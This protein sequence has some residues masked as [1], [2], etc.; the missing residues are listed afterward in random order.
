MLPPQHLAAP[1]PRTLMAQ[2]ITLKQASPALLRSWEGGGS[3][4][5]EENQVFSVGM[6]PNSLKNFGNFLFNSHHYLLISAPSPVWCQEEHQTGAWGNLGMLVSALSTG[7]NQGNCLSLK[8]NISIFPNGIILVRIQVTKLW[9]RFIKEIKRR[10][11]VNLPWNL[12]YLN[13]W[14]PLPVGK[15]R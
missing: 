14:S 3:F 11:T 6:L 1:P 15:F 4:L 8:I 5:V 13:I 2:S 12:E 9:Y 10:N 7:K